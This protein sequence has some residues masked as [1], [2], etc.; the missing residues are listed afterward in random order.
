MNLAIRLLIALGK[1]G[2]GLANFIT[3][4][5]LATWLHSGDIE[6]ITKWLRSSPQEQQQ[7]IEHLPPLNAE[8]QALLDKFQQLMD[9]Q[10]QAG[11]LHRYILTLPAGAD[12]GY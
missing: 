4:L 7:I 8:E 3:S 6:A 1:A 9:T 11:V 2:H 5:S 12:E 10:Y